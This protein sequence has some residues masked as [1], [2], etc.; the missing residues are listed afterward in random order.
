MYS[1]K[2]IELE[3]MLLM[4][5][6]MSKYQIFLCSPYYG[7]LAKLL[8]CLEVKHNNTKPSVFN[9]KRSSTSNVAVIIV[10]IFFLQPLVGI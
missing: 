7:S 1:S 4:Q 10:P 6:S 5:M 3:S 9:I 8:I 2:P